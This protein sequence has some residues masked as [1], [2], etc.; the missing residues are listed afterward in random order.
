MLWDLLWFLVDLGKYLTVVLC[1][2]QIFI[3]CECFECS[4][5]KLWGKYQEIFV[6]VIVQPIISSEVRKAAGDMRRKGAPC[7]N[8]AGLHCPQVGSR[9]GCKAV[10][11]EGFHPWGE[12]SENASRS[13]LAMHLSSL[14]GVLTLLGSLGQPWSSRWCQLGGEHPYWRE[15]AHLYACIHCDSS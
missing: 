3:S 11:G 12:G 13:A 15:M 5:A 4:I 1:T 10:E 7:V 8:E 2:K 9:P 14:A 6:W